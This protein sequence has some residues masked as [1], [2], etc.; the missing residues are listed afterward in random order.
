MTHLKSNEILICLSFSTVL[1]RF[2][3]NFNQL[4][5]DRKCERMLTFAERRQW[6]IFLIHRRIDNKLKMIIK[7]ELKELG[8]LSGGT[9]N[10]IDFLWQKIF[11]ITVKK[12]EDNW[13]TRISQFL[14]CKTMKSKSKNYLGH[15]RYDYDKNDETAT[16]NVNNYCSKHKQ[17]MSSCK[18]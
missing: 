6:E 5:V 18:K 13:W 11:M 10:V 16:G 17:T 8:E 12:D 2:H 1:T 3:S 14:E 7:N 15:I 4:V 9:G